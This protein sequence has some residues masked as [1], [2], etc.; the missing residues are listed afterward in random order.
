MRVTLQV[1]GQFGD[2]GP[3]K[4]DKG[5]CWEIRQDHEDDIWAVCMFDDYVGLFSVLLKHV[6]IP[7]TENT[8]TYWSTR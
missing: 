5:L 6:L 1:D 8:Y 7:H 2:D 4:G 3:G